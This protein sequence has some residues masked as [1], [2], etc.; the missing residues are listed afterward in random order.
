MEAREKQGATR[1]TLSVSQVHVPGIVTVHFEPQ[2]PESEDTLERA[3]SSGR[4]PSTPSM[5]PHTGW[6]GETTTQC[7]CVSVCVC[8]CVC[9]VYAKSLRLCPEERQLHSDSVCVCVCVCVC[10]QGV[11]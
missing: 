5:Y 1:D 8:V 2:G 6:G 9:R 3:G 7:L 10:V 11:C 4:W